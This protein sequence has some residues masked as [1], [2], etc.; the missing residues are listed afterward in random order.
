MANPIKKVHGNVIKIS[1]DKQGDS[2]DI[3]AR[4]WAWGPEFN[5]LDLHGRSPNANYGEQIHIHAY[6]T[7]KNNLKIK[8]NDLAFIYLRFH[9][10]VFYDTTQFDSL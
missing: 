9:K 1:L 5:P 4:Q 7:N 10:Y 3:G 6:K 2:T 8:C